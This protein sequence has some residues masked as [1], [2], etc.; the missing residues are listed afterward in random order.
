MN[1][2]V[3]AVSALFAVCGLSLFAASPAATQDW[4]IRY[5]ATHGGGGGGPTSGV[6][7]S[8]V[9]EYMRT[10]AEPTAATTAQDERTALLMRKQNAVALALLEASNSGLYALAF[11]YVTPSNGWRNVKMANRDGGGWTNVVYGCG[12]ST[13]NQHEAVLVLDALD[14][15]CSTFS[16]Y[17]GR[18]V[19]TRV[20]GDVTNSIYVGYASVTTNDYKTARGEN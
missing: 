7:Q 3:F 19:F 11:S 2:K 16:N 15:N 1:T 5:V 9:V 13:N 12:V 10:N 18:N 20:D 6:S 4:V 14:Y 8:W 17:T